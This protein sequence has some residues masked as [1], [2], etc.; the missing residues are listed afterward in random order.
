VKS[1]YFGIL[2]SNIYQYDEV[3]IF[4]VEEIDQEVL[5]SLALNKS[6]HRI[7]I[8]KNRYS[9]S[10]SHIVASDLRW[11]S[12]LRPREIVINWTKAV[13]PWLEAISQMP[14][15][16]SLTVDTTNVEWEFGKRELQ[17]IGKSSTIRHLDL[18]ADLDHRITEPLTKMHQLETLIIRPIRSECRG[19]MFGHQWACT[20]KLKRLEYHRPME[21]QFFYRLGQFR[22]LETLVIRGVESHDSELTFWCNELDA[23]DPKHEVLPPVFPKLKTLE[24]SNSIINEEGSLYFIRLQPNLESVD[25]KKSGYRLEADPIMNGTFLDTESVQILKKDYHAS[26]HYDRQ[27][28]PVH[29][30]VGFNYLFP[31]I[32]SVCVGEAFFEELVKHPSI[33]K[34]TVWDFGEGSS[35]DCPYDYE[36]PFRKLALLPNLRSLEINGVGE[37]NAD[38]FCKAVLEISSIEKVDVS[39]YS[40]PDEELANKLLSLKERGVVLNANGLFAEQK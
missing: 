19:L 37:V 21:E 9:S 27:G 33:E 26:V 14:S 1:D 12:K 23:E 5:D 39:F 6:I 40:A 38:S 24:F 22:N 15:V 18:R 29:V 2:A 11:F 7:E 31:S 4:D 36:I 10:D 20:E 3:Y 30:A 8:A 28:Q 17:L 35:P 16:E 13:E 32:P 25:W 34:V